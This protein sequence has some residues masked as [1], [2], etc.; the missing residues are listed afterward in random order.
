MIIDQLSNAARYCPLHPLF[1]RAFEFLGS[2]SLAELPPG[3]HAIDG[4]RL[5]V[6]MIQKAG[7]SPADAVLEAHRKYIDIQFVLAGTDN[8]GWK[9]AADCRQVRKP[10]SEE[11]DIVTFFDAPTSWISVGPGSF[12]IFF[13][14]DAHAPMASP[15]L[16]HKAV[17]KV[18]LRDGSI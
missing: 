3:K 13:P 12:A 9:P 16:L 5:H 4:E 11:E 6:S 15:E 14:D 2:P 10:Y 1:A 17:V 18:W 8:M 7:V